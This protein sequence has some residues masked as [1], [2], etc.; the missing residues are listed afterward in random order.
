MSEAAAVAEQPAAVETPPAVDPP[1]TSAAAAETV[2]SLPAWAQK[3]IRDT[4]EE[5]ASHRTK[6]NTVAAEHQASLD[7]IAKALGLKEADDPAAA[8]KTAAEERD[9]ARA[10]AKQAKVENA[11]LRMAAKHG[12]VPEALTDSRSFMAQLD[13]IDPAAEDFTAKLETAI[14]AAVEANPAL[15][16]APVVPARSGG[17]LPPTPPAAGQLT[18]EDVKA[19]TPD[20]VVKAKAEGRLNQLLGVK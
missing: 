12:A 3:L 17:P 7:A 20:E 11:V 18:A 1:A 2:E 14:K 13:A 8:A 16:A 6:A 19:M 5:A 10:E 4:R 15:K 9:A